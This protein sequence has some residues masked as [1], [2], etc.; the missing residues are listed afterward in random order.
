MAEIANTLN[1]MTGTQIAPVMT[2]AKVKSFLDY[3]GLK[4]YT[5][6]MQA[7]A[8]ES[9]TKFEYT[10]VD[11]IPET[12]IPDETQ[13]RY[14]YMYDN[15]SDGTQD[16]YMYVLITKEDT[17]APSEA[18]YKLIQIG[19]IALD[20]ADYYTKNEIGALLADY[21]KHTD[22]DYQETKQLAAEAASAASAALETAG[23]ANAAAIGAAGTASSAQA[24]VTALAGEV[25]KLKQ[26][27]VGGGCNCTAIEAS[28][29]YSLF[30]TL[31]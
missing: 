5:K 3:D 26:N 16:L 22:N 25:A 15:N 1:S 14:I 24:A 30:A 17:D 23:Q 7:W 2:E 28:S 27:G 8:G 10:R 18:T 19:S 6:E 13:P 12:Y 11:T 20:L 9:L 4:I 21:V 29:I 31:D